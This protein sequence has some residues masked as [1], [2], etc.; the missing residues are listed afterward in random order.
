MG[1]W[2]CGGGGWGEERLGGLKRGDGWFEDW[3]ERGWVKG[4]L[5]YDGGSGWRRWVVVLDWIGWVC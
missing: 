1:G 2:G 3:W 4:V 5:L